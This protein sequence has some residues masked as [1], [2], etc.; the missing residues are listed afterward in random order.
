LNDSV[1]F[2]VHGLAAPQGSKR[3][4]GKGIMVESSKNVKPWR[5][6][7]KY[8]AL[9]AKPSGW[10]TS[11]P[12]ALSVVFRFQRP[13]SHLGKNGLRPS[14]P[15]HC[16]SGRNGDIEKLVR[17]TND[18]LTSILFDDD[19]QVVSLTATK[20]YCTADEQPGAI[21]TLTALTPNAS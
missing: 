2:A 4:I 6:D 7:V 11:Q 1:T 17:S 14:A 8:A 10:D 21:I 18:A 12:M 13:A 19:R 5:Q 20:R 15:Q 16:T 9:A 3:H